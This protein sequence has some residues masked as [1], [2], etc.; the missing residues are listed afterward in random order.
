MACLNNHNFIILNMGLSI[1]HC[2]MKIITHT[3]FPH[4]LNILHGYTH[5]SYFH[6]HSRAACQHSWVHKWDPINTRQIQ[7]F[8]AEVSTP[9]PHLCIICYKK[10]HSNLG[11]LEHHLQINWQPAIQP[12]DTKGFTSLI[13]GLMAVFERNIKKSS[14]EHSTVLSWQ[15]QTPTI[16]LSVSATLFL[17][18]YSKLVHVSNLASHLLSSSVMKI[19]KHTYMQ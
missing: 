2:A 19:K 15:V 13:Y 10:L 4:L 16:S 6:T 18:K 5:S 17:F 8:M 12:F 11:G 9:W 7:K 3:N 14:G 1:N